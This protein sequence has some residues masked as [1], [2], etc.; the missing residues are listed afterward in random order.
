M[1]SDPLQNTKRANDYYNIYT[2]YSG[3]VQSLL[4]SH[5]QLQFNACVWANDS[6]NNRP[7]AHEAITPCSVMNYDHRIRT[8]GLEP[9]AYPRTVEMQ[10]LPRFFQE[11]RGRVIGTGAASVLRLEV[12]T[13]I[14]VH[15]KDT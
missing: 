15:R 9:G 2:V 14:G 7:R 8:V 11:N 6:G 4:I 10:L 13:R 3:G 1:Y 12:G 5:C